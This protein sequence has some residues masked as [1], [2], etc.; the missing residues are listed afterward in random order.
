[1]YMKDEVIL[2]S[3]FYSCDC[4]VFVPEQLEAT[5]G[6]KRLN[7]AQSHIN[8]SKIFFVYMRFYSLIFVV[9]VQQVYLLPTSVTTSTSTQ[10]KN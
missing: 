3:L 1:M 4:G 2:I 8:L 7:K 6:K 9:Q 5:G 10:V